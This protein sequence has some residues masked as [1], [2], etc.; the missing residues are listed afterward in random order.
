MALHTQQRTGTHLRSLCSID[1][2]EPVDNHLVLWIFEPERRVT[3]K[4]ILQLVHSPVTAKR[5]YI[6]LGHPHRITYSHHTTSLHRQHNLLGELLVD[7]SIVTLHY[8]T[9]CGEKAYSTTVGIEYRR[10]GNRLVA[11]IKRTD[12]ARCCHPERYTRR[13]D[14]GHVGSLPHHLVRQQIGTAVTR[15]V[16][17]ERT[18]LEIAVYILGNRRITLSCCRD[19]YRIVIPIYAVNHI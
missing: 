15:I 7:Y 18:F 4:H 11:H 17:N 19:L 5:D 16:H 6:T 1:I 14:L 9:R 13:F 2:V 8:G 10:L 12:V 3:Q